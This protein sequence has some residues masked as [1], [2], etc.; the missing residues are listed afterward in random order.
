MSNHSLR[1]PQSD[2]VAFR[3]MLREQLAGA[4]DTI[5]IQPDDPEQLARAH[6]DVRACFALADQL[7][8]G[9]DA[10]ADDLLA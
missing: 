2:V 3:R 5:R 7:P 4:A 6:D 9:L 10:T 8:G 1:L